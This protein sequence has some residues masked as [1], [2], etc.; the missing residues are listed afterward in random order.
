[1]FVR[2]LNFDPANGLRQIPVDL[3]E[4]FVQNNR[5]NPLRLKFPFSDM[6][7]IRFSETGDCLHSNSKSLSLTLG[8]SSGAHGYRMFTLGTRH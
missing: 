5:M 6:C 2:Y 4:V 1:M 3:D 8:L 7:L